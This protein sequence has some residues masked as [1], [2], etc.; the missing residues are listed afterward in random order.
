MK[1]IS[2]ITAAALCL[3]VTAASAEPRFV[4]R[5]PTTGVISGPMGAAPPLPLE[6]PTC[7]AVFASP[8]TVALPGFIAASWD[9]AASYLGCWLPEVEARVTMQGHGGGL[10]AADYPLGPPRPIEA[11]GLSDEFGGRIRTML[12]GNTL[13]L[14]SEPGS[15]AV[16]GMYGV[17]VS[18]IL[19]GDNPSLVMTIPLEVV[20]P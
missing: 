6:T 16:P 12:S 11:C 4:L 2:T 3:A 5:A 9:F 14:L 7:E 1:T 10:Y 17:S 20:I 18:C 8:E 15:G 13:T 19:E